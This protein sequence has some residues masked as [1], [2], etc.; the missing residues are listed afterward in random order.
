MSRRAALL[1]LPLLLAACGRGPAD[2][3]VT[4]AWIRLPAV[5]GQPAAAYFTLTAGRSPERL[6]KIES[7][8]ARQVQMHESMSGMSGMTGMSSN[9]EAPQLRSDFD[10][11][12]DDFLGS[13]SKAGK[14]RIRK[15][16]PQSGLAQ[17]D[18]IRS[19]LGPARFKSQKA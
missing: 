3:K 8:L 16:G 12:M 5:A 18:E 2:P 4:H 13:H 9:S 1:A 14:R 10:S 6:V 17:L 7:A 15:G 19:G 11:I